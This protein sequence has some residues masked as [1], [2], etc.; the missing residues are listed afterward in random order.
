MAKEKNYFD[1]V[2]KE[3]VPLIRNEG[4]IHQVD[5]L[6]RIVFPKPLRQKYGILPGNQMEFY[7]IEYGGETYV[8]VK[9]ANNFCEKANYVKA[10][11]V[12]REL[13]LEVPE[14]LLN[15]AK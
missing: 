6:G 10:V 13:N 12:L 7:T 5:S 2:M 8:G 15:L 14:R 3:N 1:I 9:V 11:E 4:T